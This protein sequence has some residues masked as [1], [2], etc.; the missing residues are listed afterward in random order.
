MW[1]T[2]APLWA[3][4]ALTVVAPTCEAALSHRVANAA[5]AARRTGLL[6][7]AREPVSSTVDAAA[8]A[9][10]EVS[11]FGPDNCVAT[12]RNE[13]GHCEVETHCKEKDISKYAVKFI[14][15]DDGGQKVRHVFAVGSFE[16]EEQFDTLIECKKCVAEKQETIEIIADVPPPK[17]AASNG[18]KN[19]LKTPQGGDPADSE[20]LGGAPLKE[21][22]NEV[23][24]LE[25]F[26]MNTSAEL[27]KLN[28]KVY[29][30]GYKP[31]LIVPDANS[32]QVANKA[33]SPGTPTVSSL[34]HHTTAHRH[35][36]V[37]S[38]RVE[39]ARV[40][41]EHRRRLEQDDDDDFDRPRAALRIAARDEAAT[42]SLAGAV[43]T[44][45]QRDDDVPA[46]QPQTSRMELS[47][48]KAPQKP[49]PLVV[50]LP[51]ATDDDAEDDGS[52]EGDVGDGQDDS[53]DL[54]P[55]L[56]ASDEDDEDASE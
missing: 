20:Q 47:T 40:R 31:R 37:E 3:A 18:A 52:G 49:K 55:S 21:L 29:S 41:R 9:H 28:A 2:L 22:R 10:S 25:A 51:T 14:C 34:V 27:Q 39:A 26:M 33:I 6:R 16:A 45:E 24:E 56:A 8:R 36:E 4:A 12:W 17:N 44:A 50:A 46:G 19:S 53:D 23:K 35:Q 30:D 1:P 15:I 13:D 54:V 5:A 48:A 11:K 42:S 38:I 43:Q 7:H 32:S